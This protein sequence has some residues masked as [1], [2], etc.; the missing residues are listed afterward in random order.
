[1]RPCGF[2]SRLSH[3]PSLAADAARF[4]WQAN[5]TPAVLRPR[6][7]LDK[8]SLH[9]III[10]PMKTEFVDVSDTRKNLTV[11][12]PSDVVDA[13]IDRIARDYRKSAKLPGFRPGKVPEKLVRQRYKD[14]IYQD[15]MRGLIPKAIDEA[16]TER[17]VE[18]VDTPDVTEVKLEQGQPL[19]FTAAFDTLP[20]VDPGDLSTLTV[21]KIDVAVQEAAVDAALERLRDRAAKS[22]PVEG[23]SVQTGDTVVMDLERRE[24]TSSDGKTDKH[25]N[26]S[27]E[28]GAPIN[29]PGFD[30]QVIGMNAGDAKTFAVHFP[31][32]YAVE[33]M[34]NTDLTY[35]VTV[36]EIRQRVVPAL[37]DEFAKDLGDFETLE[38]L[39]VRV[40]QDLETEARETAR[41]DQR[42]AL[43][44]QLAGRV[45]FELPDVL[46]DREMDRRMEEFARRLI[47]QGL[48]PRQANID[49]A[50]F[51]QAQRDQA[52]DT[53]ASAIVLD[54][55]ARREQ[56]TVG[57][58]DVEHEIGHFAEQSGRTPA[59]VRATLE[60]EGGLARL[61]V[62]L[63]REKAI[64]CA[65]G[66]ATTIEAESSAAT[67]DSTGQ[68]EE[69]R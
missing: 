1:M 13:E 33:D 61:V 45:P 18:P 55:I 3:Q 31:E 21:T 6:N 22:V 63:R 54:E 20:P 68:E 5:N 69:N 11:E 65:L 56:L 23:R 15:V 26:V 46:I 14:Q 7:V 40:R 49:W 51:R 8:R 36:R 48:D 58:A 41:R 37:D 44:K 28:I 29:P 50:Q 12:I 57:D 39:R 2:E 10:A 16:L 38:A 17:G 19:T 60:K 30:E 34:R 24:G 32:D 25:E 4:S 9:S 27:I 43:M 47:G 52:K 53:V 62:G 64:E 67:A 42:A 59:A 66:R 35:T